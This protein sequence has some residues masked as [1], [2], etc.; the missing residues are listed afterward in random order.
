MGI[1][2]FGSGVMMPARAEILTVADSRASETAAV[3]QS[4]GSPRFYVP[5]L[6]GLRFLAFFLVFIHHGPRLSELTPPSSL[7]HS[8][9]R[10]FEDFGA[11]GVD[12]FLVLSAFLIT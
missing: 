10:F 8:L 9:L 4:A 12:L 5:Q 7:T 1:T 3:N 11:C 6:D 2:E